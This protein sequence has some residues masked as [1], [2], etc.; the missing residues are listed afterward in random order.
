LNTCICSANEQIISSGRRKSAEQP[1]AG[2]TI[3]AR[4]RGHGAPEAER[5]VA[6]DRSSRLK[7]WNGSGGSLTF[8]KPRIARE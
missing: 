1:L 2:D 3:T 8:L 6:K 7:Y 4:T 5:Y